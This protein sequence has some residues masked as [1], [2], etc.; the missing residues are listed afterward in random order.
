MADRRLVLWDIDGTLIDSK[1]IGAEVFDVAIERALGVRPPARVQMAGKTDPQIV[2]EYLAMLE[3]EEVEGPGHLP[4]IL[5][6]L[7]SALS[8][9]EQ[10]IAERGRV[11][12]GVEAVL[13]RL[14][15]DPTVLQTVLTGNVAANAMVK[16]AAFGLQDRLDLEIGAYGSDHADR[17]RLVPVALDRAADQRGRR[18]GQDEVWVV[19]DAPNDLAC[20]RAGGVRCLLVA[21]GRA[22]YD[23]LA[24][25]SPDALLPDLTDTDAVVW[26]LRS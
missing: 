21:S 8:A 11:L 5:E 12:P 13:E 15:N 9:V 22:S 7:V 17:N 26:L 24:A 2:N 20:A 23:E 1:G 10:V 18:F 3:I 4:V 16:L 25:L 19:G 14:G 6:H